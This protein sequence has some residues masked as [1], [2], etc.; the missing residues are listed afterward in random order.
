MYETF[1]ELPFSCKKKE[2]SLHETD[3]S[4]YLFKIRVLKNKEKNIK[5][6]IR[7]NKKTELQKPE[8]FCKFYI[9]SKQWKIMQFTV[10]EKATLESIF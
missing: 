1:N 5:L 7:L 8:P 9:A 3:Q 4:T 6:L 10:L 2:L